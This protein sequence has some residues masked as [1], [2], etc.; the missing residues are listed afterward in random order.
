MHATNTTAPTKRHLNITPRAVI[1][2]I[3]TSIIVA[4]GN[5]IGTAHSL[6]N[7]IRDYI[8]KDGIPSIGLTFIAVLIS[9]F[10]IT[11]ILSTWT[12]K[13]PSHMKKDD[14]TTVPPIK[15]TDLMDKT[16]VIM[17]LATI[18]LWLTWIVPHYPGTMRDD[19][20]N[21]LA[22]WYGL[23]RYHPQHPMTSTLIIGSF[24][25][26]GD[27]LGTRMA[28][29]F[30]LIII[31]AIITAM[32]LSLSARYMRRI[33]TPKQMVTGAW[34][35]TILTPAT[36]QAID[37]ISK[38]M[39]NAAPLPLMFVAM[40]ETA[41]TNGRWLTE[42]KY[43]IPLTIALATY[44]TLTKRATGY[45]LAIAWVII[46]IG[47]VARKGHAIAPLSMS[48]I[49]AMIA[50]MAV[51]PI[52]DATLDVDAHARD[53]NPLTM[54]G[55]P[56]NQAIRS[57]VDDT[58][59][60]IPITDHDRRLLTC[61]VTDP[62]KA[63]RTY[64]PH[65]TDEMGWIT[66]GDATYSQLLDLWSHRIDHHATSYMDS[67]LDLAGGWMTLHDRITYAHSVKGDLDTPERMRAWTDAI[68]HGDR[69]KADE[70]VSHLTT[71]E[72]R[73]LTAIRQAEDTIYDTILMRVPLLDSTG[74]YCLAIPVM[75]LS[76]LI[77]RKNK[78]GTT[79][80]GLILAQSIT[81]AIGPM[82][83]YW[84]SIPSLVTLPIVGSLPLAPKDTYEP[85]HNKKTPARI[86][87]GQKRHTHK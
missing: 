24:A 27:M 47:I 46:A 41:R 72:P 8:D 14:E 67:W 32:T 6:Y 68:A 54:A 15:L 26:I 18:A 78:W 39:L 64:N 71:S 52:L 33:G 60:S 85:D 74:L 35:L 36:W 49:P 80:M 82:V 20:I 53:T 2:S 40:T 66:R 51:T 61:I 7:G 48:I 87:M 9:A 55:V 62:D 4:S 38:D 57:Y 1:I 3:I 22:Q 59:Q 28:G 69:D 5:T 42:R 43:R 65:R 16:F 84:Y 56:L 11:L 21:Q 30:I 75:T 45:V 19:T 81:Y 58:D 83:L 70:F 34:L 25:S 76:I 86:T 73:W 44:L 10:L 37:A 13:K 12:S 63:I 31:Q 50:T 77:I 79:V 29:L 17:T 23:T